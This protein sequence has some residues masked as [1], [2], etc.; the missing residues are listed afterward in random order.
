MRRAKG[1]LIAALLGASVLL[2]PSA[3]SAWPLL[4]RFCYGD[5]QRPSYSPL[6]YWAPGPARVSDCVHGPRL[7]SY[8]PDTHPD[9]PPTYT[10]L[11]FPCQPADPAATLIPVPPDRGVGSAP[12]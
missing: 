6:R 4:D 12:R 10:V 2:I 8:A 11:K 5:C 9:I 3:A 1:L 7:S